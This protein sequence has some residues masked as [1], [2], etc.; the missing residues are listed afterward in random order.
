[1]TNRMPSVVRDHAL[2]IAHH[3]MGHY[4]VARALGFATGGVTLSVTMDLRHQGGA[5]ITLARPISSMEA[6]KAHLEARMMV[7]LAGA[8]GQTLSSSGKR[9]DKSK[10]VAILKGAQGAEQDYAK[11]KELQH[12]LRNITCPETEPASSERIS[13]E[14]KAM[15]DRV[16][17]RT[18]EVVEDL[19]DTITE[20][21]SVLVDSMVIVEQWGRAA[22]TYEVVFTREMI[23]RLG[24]VQ[25][26]PALGVWA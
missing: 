19:A 23:E 16:W 22:D 20:L 14:L 25:A 17:S 18:Q 6:M 12:L 21:G 11:V 1:M 13:A 9:V 15:T 3:E 4:V 26:I 8:M 7:L 5:A 10:A 2:Q 24:P